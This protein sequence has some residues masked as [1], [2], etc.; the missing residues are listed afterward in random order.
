[1]IALYHNF[2]MLENI[3]S[4]KTKQANILM[5]KRKPFQV[6]LLSHSATTRT[7]A[8]GCSAAPPSTTWPARYPRLHPDLLL[9]AQQGHVSP[10]NPGQ[11]GVAQ[12]HQPRDGRIDDPQRAQHARLP[13]P[14]LLRRT[15]ATTQLNTHLILERKRLEEKIRYLKEEM[16]AEKRK[17]AKAEINCKKNQNGIDKAQNSLNEL[18]LRSERLN[19]NI[20]AANHDC[21]VHRHHLNSLRRENSEKERQ[22]NEQ[23]DNCANLDNECHNLKN[24]LMD[25][26]K[27]RLRLKADLISE[28]KVMT[29]QSILQKEL[30]QERAVLML[31]INKYVAANRL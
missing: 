19:E 29:G 25:E 7:L 15:P 11:V 24:S 28:Q 13:H 16:A 22:K 23:A 17:L 31:E 8:V 12:P 18:G 26:D 9:P 3:V 20:Q 30:E 10:Q 6:Y 4:Q 1:M 27:L 2:I 21:S 5:A 14:Q